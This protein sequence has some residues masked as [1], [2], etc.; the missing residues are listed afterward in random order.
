M[1]EK[2]IEVMQDAKLIKIAYSATSRFKK[3]M[4]KEE[5]DNCIINAVWK[6]LKTYEPESGC[7]F[8]SYLY[9]GVIMECQAFYKMNIHKKE[10]SYTTASTEYTYKTLDYIDM[11]D[12]I[13]TCCEDPDLIYDRYYKNMSIQEIADKTKKSGET[14][15][16]K[17]K[18]DLQRLKKNLI[19]SV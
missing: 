17:I 10:F 3:N 2:I 12:E 4:S 14:I 15:R 13:F 8:S 16:N 18:K 11:M 1:N 7:K 9:L 6:A 5:I 19:N